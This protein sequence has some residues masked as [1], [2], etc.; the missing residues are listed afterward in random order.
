[1]NDLKKQPQLSK[2]KLLSAHQCLKMLHL[3]WHR[4]DLAEVSEATEAAYRTGNEVGDVAKQIYADFPI[5][6]ATFRHKGVLV[7]VDV[8][9][10]DG[11]GWRALEIKASTKV[12]P[13][14]KI[15]CAIQW[16]VM[17]G[18]GLPVKSISLGHVNNRFVYGG[19][20][21][22]EGLIAEE[23]LTEEA[24]RWRC[25]RRHYR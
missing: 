23:D 10:P 14:H 4:S 9:I 6:E 17:R 12:K 1:M 7:R 24:P 8:L 5:F 25:S 18:V 16:W 21:D 22:Y 3:E 15:D 11:D 13:E 2:S 20:G 19:D